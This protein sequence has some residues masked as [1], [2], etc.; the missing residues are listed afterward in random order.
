V[1][2]RPPQTLDE[3]RALRA[4]ARIVDSRSRFAAQW[5]RAVEALGGPGVESL[6]KSPERTAQGFAEEIRRRLDWRATAWEPLIA[7]L[8]AV[9]FSW[10][11]WL[12]EHPPVPGDHGELTRVQRAATA[13]WRK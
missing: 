1:E 7:E 6:G 12:S 8:N 10:E 3:F 13:D 4:L 5:R 11:R 2:D 9:G